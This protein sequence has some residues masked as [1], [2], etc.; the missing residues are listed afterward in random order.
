MSLLGT[1]SHDFFKRNVQEKV[2]CRVQ[3]DAFA[4]WINRLLVPT[5]TQAL[6]T[7]KKYDRWPAI[8]STRTV[9]A[10][11]RL[12]STR[13]ARA[14]PSIDSSSSV[15]GA[16][17]GRTRR[18]WR[19]HLIQ[20]QPPSDCRSRASQRTIRT[21]SKLVQVRVQVQHVIECDVLRLATRTD[22]CLLPFVHRIASFVWFPPKTY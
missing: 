15:S 14:T 20:H 7:L 3:A 5:H 2:L 10:Q 16:C 12:L 17:S 4:R 8:R 18:R 19:S 1:S 11:F 21:G 22:S 9:P 13:P 6:E